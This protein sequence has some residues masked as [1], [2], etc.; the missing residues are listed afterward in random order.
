MN[1]NK[2]VISIIIIILLAGAGAFYFFYFQKGDFSSNG[3]TYQGTIHLGTVQF[4]GYATLYV[5]RDKGF[6]KEAGLDVALKNYVSLGDLSRDYTSGALEGRANLAFEAVQESMR[7]FDQRIVAIIDHSNGA[8]GVLAKDG[9]SSISDLKGKKVAYEKGTLEEYFL[10]SLLRKASLTTRDVI[11]IDADP[12]KAVAKLT[13]G[14]VDVAVMYEPF[15]SS[16]LNNPGVRVLATSKDTPN[17]ITDVLTFNADFVTKYPATVAAFVE[18]YFK[19]R[20]YMKAHPDETAAIV[21]KELGISPEEATMQLQGVTIL[22]HA[23]NLTELQ[24]GSSLS[25][26]YIHLSELAQFIFSLGQA[27]TRI[28]TDSMIDPTFVRELK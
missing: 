12:E 18:A 13:S 1:K 15:L 21:G 14:E 2:L 10:A 20:E 24:P 27:P 19:A 9:I 8:D 22:D 28:N 5:A 16:G 11:L 3:G 4:P 26:L 25:S 7:G 17:A 23:G 6:F